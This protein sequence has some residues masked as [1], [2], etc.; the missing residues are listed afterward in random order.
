MTR[1][2]VMQL[3]REDTDSNFWVSLNDCDKH[4]L[5]LYLAAHSDSL[6]NDVE[7]AIKQYKKE[8]EE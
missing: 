4:E 7:K 6:Y 3:F 1:E 5:M 8:I 2:Q